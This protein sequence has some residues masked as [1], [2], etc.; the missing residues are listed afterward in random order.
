MTSPSRALAVAAGAVLLAA[1]SASAAPLAPGTTRLID[2]PSGDAPL[3]R[4]DNNYSIRGSGRGLSADGRYAIFESDADGLAIATG[5]SRSLRYVFVRDRVAGTIEN[6]CRASGGALG[7]QGCANGTISPNG[8]YVAFTSSSPNLA[9]PAPNVFG[10]YVHDRVTHQTTLMSRQNGVGGAIDQGFPSSASVADNGTVAFQTFTALDPAIDTA[11]SHLD[12]YSRTLAGVTKLVSQ[13]AGAV[14]NGN[15]SEPAIS[16]D[17]SLVAFSSTSSNLSAGD[18]NTTP[19]VY[20]APVGGGASVLKSRIGTAGAVGNGPSLSP[21]LSQDGLELAYQTYATNL[22]ATPDGNGH[23]DIVLRRDPAGTNTPVSVVDGSASTLI[24]EG[25]LAPQV[26][27]DGA[28]VS[29]VSTQSLPGGSLG[30]VMLRTVAS[31]ST[32]IVGRRPGL[33]G[34]VVDAGA[35]AVSSDGKSVMFSTSE[36]DGGL[37]EQLWVR[38]VAAGTNDRLVRAGTDDMPVQAASAS[39]GDTSADGRYTVFTSNALGLGA[40]ADGRSHVFLRDERSATT[41]QLDRRVGSTVSAEDARISDDGKLVIFEG[42]GN[43]LAPGDEAG[44]AHV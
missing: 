14:G 27:S 35:G 3:P 25:G 18:P 39:V 5:G 24:A 9:S 42:F 10:L 31:N 36:L 13:A 20:V 21:S 19:D 7:T 44:Q 40:D 15:S 38:D 4:D 29:F 43:G 32:V 23:G 33:G 16:G 41:T 26:S 8:R 37:A 28:F 30:R 6:V 17:G 11:N 22:F 12:V 1:G 2:R 34:D